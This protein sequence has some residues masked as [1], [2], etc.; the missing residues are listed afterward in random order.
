MVGLIFQNYIL[1]LIKLQPKKNDSKY[2][3]CSKGKMYRVDRLRKHFI[4]QFLEY[5]ES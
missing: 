1:A 3:Y 4:L 5:I 2:F